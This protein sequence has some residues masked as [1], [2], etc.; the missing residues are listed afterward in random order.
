VTL[1]TL[2]CKLYNTSQPYLRPLV[3][4]PVRTYVIFGH[5]DY[6]IGV[7]DAFQSRGQPCE[8]RLPIG[9]WDRGGDAEVEVAVALRGMDCFR[10]FGVPANSAEPS[11]I[12]IR[13][14]LRIISHPPHKPTT[15]Q[16]TPRLTR[17]LRNG[18][19]TSFSSSPGE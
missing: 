5:H 13:P 16:T 18:K 6:S 19:H 9:V 1:V 15:L 8:Q 2:F 12:N 14:R 4:Q 11:Q 17:A 7:S 10:C 3:P